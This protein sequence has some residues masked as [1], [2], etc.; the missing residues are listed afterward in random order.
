MINCDLSIERIA[1]IVAM[2]NESKPIVDQL[3]M[4]QVDSRHLGFNPKLCLEVFHATIRN[5]DVFLVTNGK[6][7][8]HG[9][10]RV[11]TQPAALTTY[12]T[13]VALKPDTIISAGT[14]GGL[15][16]SQIGDV[17]VSDSPIV[18]FDRVIRL[19]K[20]EEYGVGY[21][22]YLSVLS[23]AKA[24]GLKL[25]KVATG[26]SLDPSS[27][28]LSELER[29][30]ADVVDMEAASV[31][32]VAQRLEVRMIAIKSVTNFLN[33]ELHTDFLK[34]YEIAVKNLAE[35][36]SLLIPCILG[37]KPSELSSISSENMSKLKINPEKN[38]LRSRL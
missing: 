28:D 26:S 16:D 11:S 33:K 8:A 1:I 9:V 22:N 19:P 6:D 25:G 20:F 3:K 23:L 7:L 24:S 12:A 31:A 29:L 14:A 32:E 30:K 15:K 38:K 27:R 13:I 5:R 21:F 4:K 35:R 18:Y 34:N 2:E 36:V 37:R 10:D 17:Y